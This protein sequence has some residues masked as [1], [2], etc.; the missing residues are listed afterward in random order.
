MPISKILELYTRSGQSLIENGLNEA[1]LPVREAGVALN[2]FEQ[3]RWRVLG[4]DVY[5]LT[6]AGRFESTYE[7]W[8]YEGHSA[9]ESV[10]VAREFI[11]G[12]AGRSAHIVFVVDDHD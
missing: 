11:E 8:S 4:G 9:D 1:A 12:L 6:D 10:A 5:H 2:L 3:Q 7:N